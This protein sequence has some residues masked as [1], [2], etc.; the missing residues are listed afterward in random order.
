[1]NVS[2][3]GQRPRGLPNGLGPGARPVQDHRNG[4]NMSVTST[5]SANDSRDTAGPEMSGAEMFEDEKKRI[6]ESCFG[7]KE[8]DGSGQLFNLREK[9]SQD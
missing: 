7:K 3:A 9:C 4:S 5:A 1:M 2:T 6:I 8:P